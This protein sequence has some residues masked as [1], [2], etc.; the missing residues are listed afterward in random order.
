MKSEACAIC[1]K[2]KAPF[3]CGLC[4]VALCKSCAQV[5]ADE[6]FAFLAKRPPELAHGVY[7]APCFDSKVAEPLQSYN[8]TLDRAR[9]VNVYTKEQ[10]KETR[11]LKRTEKPL[12]VE[13]CAD[14]EETLLRLAFLAAQAGFNSIIDVEI[15]SKKVRD[16]AYQTTMYTGTAVPIQL[17]ENQ[18]GLARPA[19]KNPN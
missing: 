12:R 14:E 11:L 3:H 8:E 7:C 4:E 15:N 16:H 10:A 2:P 18:T 19:L 1:Q 17:A 9:E 5:L 6:D 13:A